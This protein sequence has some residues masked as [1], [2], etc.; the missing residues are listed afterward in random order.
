MARRDGDRQVPRRDVGTA[1]SSGTGTATRRCPWMQGSTEMAIRQVARRDDD[2]QW[3]VE[4]VIEKLRVDGGT[5][6]SSA[7]GTAT[8]RRPWVPDSVD[9]RTKT[10]QHRDGDPISGS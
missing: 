9:L 4:M 2:G 10:V 7:A 8:R 6:N 5:A 3:L 1:N